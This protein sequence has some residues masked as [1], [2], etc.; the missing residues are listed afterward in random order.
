MEALAAETQALTALEAQLRAELRELRARREASETT[1]SERSAELENMVSTRFFMCANTEALSARPDL[2]LQIL[3][4]VPDAAP[5]V[6][7]RARLSVRLCVC[8]RARVC[9]CVSLA[10]S[11]ALSRTHLSL[12]SNSSLS[13]CPAARRLSPPT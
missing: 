4:N 13:L 12:L 9:A 1:L 8:A 11:R 3:A 6:T 10:L 7:P 5:A 2:L